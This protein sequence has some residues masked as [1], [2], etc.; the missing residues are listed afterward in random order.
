MN[1]NYMNLT[2]YGPEPFVTNVERAAMMN[3]N[4]RTALWTGEHLQMTLMQINQGEDIGLEV[5]PTLD[6]YL[7]IINGNGI[8]MMGKTETQ[9]NY[10]KNVQNGC[11]IFV[12]AGT[13]HNVIN[14]G[15]RPIK[16]FSIYAPPAHPHGT[17]HQTKEIA[18]Q[19]EGHY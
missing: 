16:L 17:V 13:W 12:P 11:G 19:G 14:T 9:L 6:Q 10:Q 5:H 15:N 7:M 4:Y 8:A 1:N 3:N 2:D 18:E